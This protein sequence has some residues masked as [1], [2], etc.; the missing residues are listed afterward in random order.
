[1]GGWADG[2]MGADGIGE[3]GCGWYRDLL[4]TINILIKK[5]I[6]LP[7][8]MIMSTLMNEI[9]RRDQDERG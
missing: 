8:K 1:M 7:I 3:D 4:L 9:E 2:R 5:E 6:I